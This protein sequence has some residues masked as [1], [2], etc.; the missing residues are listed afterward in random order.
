MDKELMFGLTPQDL[1]LIKDVLRRHQDV[2]EALVCDPSEADEFRGVT[3][4]VGHPNLD[5]LKFTEVDV[6]VRWLSGID[7]EDP[8]GRGDRAV[9]E[10]GSFEF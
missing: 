9:G 7:F 6:P 10:A 4:G 1:K 8:V 2:E 3:V 5:I